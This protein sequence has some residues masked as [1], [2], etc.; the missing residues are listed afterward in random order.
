MPRMSAVVLVPDEYQGVRRLVDHLHAQTRRS[1]LEIVLVAPAGTPGLQDDPRLGDFA[2]V[3]VVPYPVLESPAGA[4]AAGIRAASSPVVV[5]TEDHSLPEPDWAEALMEAH[6]GEWAVAG[7]AVRNGN[8]R[9][10][11]SW[12]NFLIEYSEWLDPHPGGELRHLP[13]HN[14]AYK[15]DLLLE[16]GDRLE[17]WLDTE[18]LLHW[19]LRARGHRLLLVP[20]ARTRHFNF[21]QLGPALALRFRFGRLFGGMR[22]VPWGLPR[23]LFYAA[24]SPLIPLVRAAR[25]LRELGRPGRF[26]P[27]DLLRLPWL[28]LLL[29]VD[30]AGEM[31]GYL[32]G[33]GEM[34]SLIARVD[35][36]R[37]RYMD[38]Q[39]RE[40][41]TGGERVR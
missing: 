31:T 25:I 30:A 10:P 16:Y 33:Q 23:R 37:E 8:P 41:Y 39:D 9:S 14:S 26:R 36:H 28:L 29:G 20:G 21:S 15:R 2:G 24:A 4:R 7:P 11:V 40:E 38:R 1:D 35:F 22:R 6:R 17:W 13:G 32:A 18:S 5:M 34:A 3:R 12:A 19:D 27:G